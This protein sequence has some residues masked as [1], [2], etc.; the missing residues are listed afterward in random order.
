MISG[1]WPKGP[2]FTRSL[3][4]SC[5]ISCSRSRT[6]SILLFSEWNII[7]KDC[8]GDLKKKPY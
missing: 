4:Y 7:A 2:V 8:G 3:V 6:T 5:G 1:N